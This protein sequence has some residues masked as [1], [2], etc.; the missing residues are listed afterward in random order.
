MIDARR[1][2]QTASLLPR[3][4][5]APARVNSVQRSRHSSSGCRRGDAA[6]R[7]RGRVRQRHRSAR[8]GEPGARSQRRSAR[9]GD[10]FSTRASVERALSRLV[11]ACVGAPWLRRPREV[12]GGERRPRPTR[13]EEPAGRR[14]AA[15]V[16]RSGSSTRVVPRSRCAHGRDKNPTSGARDEPTARS[17]CSGVRAMCAQPPN[18]NRRSSHGLTVGLAAA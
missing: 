2:S 10:D 4:A 12:N 9:P 5:T 3:A 8:E 13:R 15:I 17:N 11:T 6:R 16:S 1:T 18:T 7:A 14:G